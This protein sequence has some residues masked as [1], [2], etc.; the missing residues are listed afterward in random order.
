MNQHISIE[1]NLFI[2]DD[3]YKEFVENKG[4]IY[5]NK[6]KNFYYRWINYPKLFEKS[7]IELIKKYLP[8]NAKVLELG[9]FI[10]ATAC[11][12]NKLLHEYPELHTV[13]ELDR[14]IALYLEKNKQLNNC[15]FNI[16]SGAIDKIPININYD[17]IIMDIEGDEYS[18][19]LNNQQYIK[20]HIKCLIIEFHSKYHCKD[21]KKI[22]N[23]LR[24]QTA[25][26]LN[27]QFLKIDNIG[28]CYVYK[29]K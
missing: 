27:K 3:Y 18:F 10:G 8:S 13:V 16:I 20:N 17:T 5:H 22:P 7:E 9:G 24:E 21:N 23:Q 6:S 11:L 26:F 19:L 12:I 2:F 4:I 1:N 25:A 29:N 15:K 28:E 14:T